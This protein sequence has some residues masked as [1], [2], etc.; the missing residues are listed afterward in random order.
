MP[1]FPGLHQFPHERRFKQWT[2]DD[3]KALMKVYLAA[4]TEYLLE[5]I[6][7]CLSAFMD[8][9]CLVRRSD[10]DEQTLKSVKDAVQRFHHYQEAFQVTGV[11]DDFS[12]PRQHA[13]VHY[14]THI[15]EFSAPNG[16]CSSITE[17]RHITAVKKPWRWSN[18]YN[19][20][21][22][23]LLTNQHL[24]KLA[25]LQSDLI[26]QG[27]LMPL[28]PAPPDPFENG[29]EDEGAIDGDSILGEVTLA[30]VPEHLYPKDLLSLGHYIGQMNLDELTQHFL[31]DQLSDGA[32]NTQI[33][34]EI[35]ST[36]HVFHSAIATF[37]APSDI[38][39]IR[40][41]HRE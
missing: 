20:L 11:C 26:Q 25:A 13:I 2:G 28:Y 5:S 14:P 7:K 30:K 21:S 12:L 41:M 10:F 38:S 39:S 18:R 40:G 27:L 35:T 4:V 29:T 34:H 15:M 31:C 8:F 23:M 1:L 33:H 17:S 36:V 19:A 32:D 9:C 6:M 3:S 37:Y 16:L 22:Q 24:D